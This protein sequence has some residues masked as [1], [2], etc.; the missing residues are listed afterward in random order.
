MRGTRDYAVITAAYWAFTL[1]DGALRML[2][3]LHL[4][5]L[6]FAPLELAGLFLLYEFFGIVTNLVGGWLGARRG[7][8]LTLTAGLGL[9]VGAL[10]M[11]LVDDSLLTVP[12][13]MSAQALSGIA[14]DLT[15]MSAKSYVKLLVPSGD[16]G[17]LLRWVAWLTGSKN[18]LKGVGFF[19]GGGLLGAVGFRGACLGLAI[20][21]GLTLLG[22]LMLLPPAEGGRGRTDRVLRF[23]SGDRRLDMLSAARLFLFASRDAWFVVALPVFLTTELGWSY[24]GVG[25]F[26]A[27]WIIG[28]GAV[29]AFAPA[30]VGAR[31]EGGHHPDGRKLGMMSLLL[32]VPLSGI[33]L[34]LAL[35][36][37]AK[38][39]LM[40]GLAGFGV[41]F[42]LNSAI[43]SY[44]V[45]H[46]ASEDR[47]SQS[48]GFYYSANATG[49]LIGT[50][51][52]GLLYGAWAGQGG[53]VA[54]LVAAS[55]LVSLS[56]VLCIPLS[57][58]ESAQVEPKGGGVTTT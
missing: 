19:L 34:S 22:S 35:G 21:I 58:A 40:I 51:L 50:A 32:L 17:G 47:L 29:Q 25:A 23:R 26:L 2:V 52:S 30:L 13:V 24:G 38:P 11:L 56:A 20:G 44:L 7:L 6:G 54:T 43:H 9:Q 18:T 1:S 36:A 14:K 4:H 49:R 46:Y 57:R 55:V 39:T 12:W 10:G 33:L 8:K 53:L 37:P 31:G 48:V 27:A 3:L 45:V 16:S 28:Y 15:K 5:E 42:A 41:I